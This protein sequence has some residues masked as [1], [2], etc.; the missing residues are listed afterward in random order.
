[1]DNVPMN[2]LNSSEVRRLKA[3]AQVLKATL[4]V[5]RSGLSGPFL[6]ALDEAL[7]HHALLKVKFDEFKDQRK[8]LAAQMAERSGSHLITVV[9]HVAVLYRP[10]PAPETPAQ[11]IVPQ[12]P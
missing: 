2:S 9:G 7:T 8:E 12:Q 6:Q 10:K 1:M 11:S 4:K 3:Q 5:G